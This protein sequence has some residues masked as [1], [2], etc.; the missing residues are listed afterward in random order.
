MYSR[1]LQLNDAHRCYFDVNS[2]QMRI[3]WCSRSIFASLC[4]F[5][6]SRR[7][8]LEKLKCRE[9]FSLSRLHYLRSFFVLPFYPLSK[10]VLLYNLRLLNMQFLLLL[11]HTPQQNANAV[12]ICLLLPYSHSKQSEI[13]VFTP[14]SSC[15]AYNGKMNVMFFLLLGLRHS[16]GNES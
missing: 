15:C 3:C 14:C 9:F 16:Q 7:T 4:A 10:C 12:Y 2:S 8:V 11:L 13:V 1:R 6:Y 5:V